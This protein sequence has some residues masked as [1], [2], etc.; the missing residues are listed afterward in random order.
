MWVQFRKKGREKWMARRK[1]RDKRWISEKSWYYGLFFSGRFFPLVTVLSGFHGNNPFLP[2][3]QRPSG[4]RWGGHLL[5]MRHSRGGSVLKQGQQ[6]K[7]DCLAFKLSAFGLHCCCLAPCLK[8]QEDKRDTME[9]RKQGKRWLQ[10]LYNN[11]GHA[12]SPHLFLTSSQYNR[13]SITVFHS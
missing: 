3:R 7:K 5:Q 13:C 8:R 10:E 9:K 12:G 6:R 1:K 4:K 11:R 2:Q